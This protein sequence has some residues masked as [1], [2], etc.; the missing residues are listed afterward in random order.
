MCAINSRRSDKMLNA[1]STEAYRS[2]MR[3]RH[4]AVITKGG[5]LLATGHNH[6][7]TRFSGPLAS[8]DAIVL[9][10]EMGVEGGGGG[11]GYSSAGPSSNT[12][13]SGGS[14]SSSAGSSATSSSSSSASEGGHH[15]ASGSH[16]ASSSSSSSA[17]SSSA[18]HH[19]QSGGTSTSSQS[20]S[21][22]HSHSSSATTSI[23]HT[24]SNGSSNTGCGSGGGGAGASHSVGQHSFSMHAEMHA[25]TLALRGARPQRHKSHV[26]IDPHLAALA[27]A[28]SS[29]TTCNTPSKSKKLRGGLNPAVESDGVKKKKKT[30]K[31]GKKVS[32]GG[33][34]AGVI[35]HP[36]GGGVG[37]GVVNI[38]SA[39]AATTVPPPDSGFGAPSS[40][41]RGADMYVVRLLQDAESKA[42]ARA[43]RRA[44]T[45]NSNTSAQRTPANNSAAGT[46]WAQT[47]EDEYGSGGGREPKYADSRPCWRC[48]KWMEW[49]GIK[50]VFWTD[51]NGVWEGAK[52]VQLLYGPF[53]SPPNPHSSTSSSDADSDTDTSSG[54][55][56]P[57]STNTVP[58]F[59]P[60][61]H[62][63]RY[64]QAAIVQ[65]AR[66]GIAGGAQHRKKGR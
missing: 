16:T 17:S 28:A 57:R 5:K 43:K 24:A 53:P 9:P 10:F 61:I 38:S 31:G 4:G 14:S 22:T 51:E 45:T 35:H 62:I 44:L 52:V 13:N 54:G 37:G 49:A 7:R 19:P 30:G 56:G 42:R 64:E 66:A 8:N 47:H 40:R 27:L 48:L 50:R 18:S 34:S 65:A 60:A 11:S 2:Q 63:T 58:A 29:F 32:K 6:V 1:A 25:I 59:Y 55:G 46:G 20:N 33:S 15:S 23:S 36:Q 39:A 3:F 26:S 21:D 12:V 41:L